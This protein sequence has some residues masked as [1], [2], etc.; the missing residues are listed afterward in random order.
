MYMKRDRAALM[1]AAAYETNG[2]GHLR[3]RDV[4]ISLTQSEI[5]EAAREEADRIDAEDHHDVV[6]LAP[7]RADSSRSPALQAQ[8]DTSVRKLES[9]IYIIAA[10]VTALDAIEG[11]L[12]QVRTQIDA[13]RG[14]GAA[15]NIE[16]ARETIRFLAEHVTTI[17]QRIDSQ[18]VNFL[19]DVR[20]DL[21]FIELDADDM[22]REIDLELT[23]ISLEKL[24]AY[25]LRNG[26][27]NADQLCLLVD[28]V[29]QVVHNNLHVL[30]SMILV[31]L[32]SRDYTDEVARLVLDDAIDIARSNG[33]R[34]IAG[35]RGIPGLQLRLE[36]PAAAEAY[37]GYGGYPDDVGRQGVPIVPPP[38]QLPPP[39]PSI[40]ERARVS[41][42]ALLAQLRASG[43]A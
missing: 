16:K 28:A 37:Q 30:S 43:A 38:A 35:T 10:A 32:A 19:R 3:I 11:K 39:A 27:E 41:L 9:S 26:V 8:Y 4:A 22:S 42:M 21:K 15:V 29:E 31:L 2:G 5:D 13:L 17:V 40:A 18:C 33:Q 20:V 34:M 14:R 6:D 24:L 1:N 23:L 36:Q 12:A 7:M 25:K